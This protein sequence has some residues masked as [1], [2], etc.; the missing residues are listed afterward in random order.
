MLQG[1]PDS[2]KF[3]GVTV[4]SS[5]PTESNSYAL[6]QRLNAMGNTIDVEDL[7][8]IVT[9]RVDMTCDWE[10]PQ[11]DDESLVALA[12]YVVS[13]LKK[14]DVTGK[15]QRP[16][17]APREQELLD[18]IRSQNM[19]YSSRNSRYSVD[20][21][22]YAFVAEIDNATVAEGYKQ[23]VADGKQAVEAMAQASGMTSL[24][25]TSISSNRQT[26][27]QTTYSSG[28][29]SRKDILSPSDKEILS[30]TIDDLRY[31]IRVHMQYTVSE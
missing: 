31:V 13:S 20:E 27:S 19:V 2:V 25:L 9:A 14:P 17:L 10:L 18:T 22:R 1:L 15:N 4:E 11:S 16:E 5:D 24:Q 7:P 21:I 28:S 29:R 30:A 23:A 3:S 6:T 8:T 12:E 26:V